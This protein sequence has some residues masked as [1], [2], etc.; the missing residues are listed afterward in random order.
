MPGARAAPDPGEVPQRAQGGRERALGRVVEAAVLE[1]QPAARDADLGSL[2]HQ[3]EHPVERAR[4]TRVSG[5][6]QST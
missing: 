5:L 4:V 1:L 6:R 3:L 2:V